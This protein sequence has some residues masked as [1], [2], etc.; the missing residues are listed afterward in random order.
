MEE[1][2]RNGVALAKLAKFM[3]PNVKF[4][5]FDEDLSYYQEHGLNFRHTDNINAFLRSLEKV[6]LPAIFYPET[7]DV[8]DLKNMPKLCYCIHALSLHMFKLGLAPQINDLEGLL[9]FTEE[10]ISGCGQHYLLEQ[11]ETIACGQ[12]AHFYLKSWI[13]PR[14]V[15][16]HNLTTEK[17]WTRP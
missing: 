8:Y 3:V 16:L 1:N 17:L 10:E 6:K 4:K 11:A 2:L 14:S 9:K 13:F 12:S 7:T 15:R 5:I